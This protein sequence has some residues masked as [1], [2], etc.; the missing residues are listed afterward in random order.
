MQYG[1]ARVSTAT[2]CL[3]RQLCELLKVGILKENIFT[4]KESGK[5]FNRTNYKKLLK[6]MKPGDT[7][8]I[9]SIDRLGRNY[10]MILDEW[11]TLTKSKGIDIVVI[12][13]P[14]LDTRIDGNNLVGKFIADVVLQVL[15]FVAENERETMKQRQSEGIR[16][17][18]LRGVKFGRPQIET[19][20][21]FSNIVDLYKQKEISSSEACKLSGLSRGTF[22]RKMNS[23]N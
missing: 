7:L 21:D 19:P 2:Q 14:L 16:M 22:F 17:A 9:K 11:K 4:D 8:F 15:S 12:D 10:Y 18:K 13:M 1:Y 3:D 20:K 6:K 23:L 5:D